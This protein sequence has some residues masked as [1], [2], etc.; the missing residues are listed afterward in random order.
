MKQT[1]TYSSDKWQKLLDPIEELD[2]LKAERQ[3]KAMIAKVKADGQEIKRRV[4]HHIEANPCWGLAD[5]IRKF[6]LH[7]DV[8]KEMDNGIIEVTFYSDES[9]RTECF[10]THLTEVSGLVAIDRERN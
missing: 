8:T 5:T 2:P 3:A 9:Y 10:S 4:M 6:G 7:W 1:S